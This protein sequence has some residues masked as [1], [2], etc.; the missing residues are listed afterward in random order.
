MLPPLSERIALGV[1]PTPLSPLR[2]LSEHLG[3]P[4]I[5]IKRDD[6]SGLALGGNKVRKLEYLLQNAL[7]EGADTLITAG[8]IQSNHCRQ[9]AAAAASLGLEC[10][11][12]LGGYA[13]PLLQ[14]NLLLDSLF[15]AHLHFAG[16]KRKGE[17]IPALAESL[18]A[19]GKRP[20]V[21]P[22]GGS[23]KLGALGFANALVELCRQTQEPFS[24]I[25]FAS[26]S[27]GTHAGLLAAAKWMA[28]PTQILGIRIDKEENNGSP[29]QQ[30]LLSLSQ[31]VLTDLEPLAN[32]SAE[33]IVLNEDY[34]GQGY[35]VMGEPEQEA[36]SLMA[37]LEGIL[38][39]PVY[40]G[41]AMA[42]LL[43]LVQ[44]GHFSAEDKILFWHTGGAPA[45][46]A[47]A[48]EWAANRHL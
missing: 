38:L 48:D 31:D 29:F 9:T 39:D 33:D 25:V 17:D 6:L 14:G 36:I 15:G 21:V 26:S 2:R 16:S 40:T 7:T 28:L 41:R 35:G 19:A 37:S 10:H 20:Y 34:L 44:K 8:A 27:G 5:W 46:F 1:F 23:N 12:V 47:Y 32:L 18:I 43:D 13:P 3:G 22:Y 30:Q 24:H 4:S 42:G 11:L 45:I